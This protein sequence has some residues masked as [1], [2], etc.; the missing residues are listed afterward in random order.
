MISLVLHKIWAPGA[1]VVF[2][3]ASGTSVGQALLALLLGLIGL[4]LNHRT[5]QIHVLVNQR[6]TDATEQIRVQNQAMAAQDTRILALEQ[7][8]KITPGGAIPPA[9][10][11]AP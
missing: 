2:A 5:K 8:L 1:L 11:A 7:A 6:M 3:F 10:S 4:W 9:G